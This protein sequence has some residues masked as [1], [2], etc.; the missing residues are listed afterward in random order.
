LADYDIED[1]ANLE[2]TLKKQTEKLNALRR[3]VRKLKFV[4]I[5]SAGY[6]SSIAYKSFDGGM[7]KLNFDPLEIDVIEV[8]DSNGNTKLKFAI[9]ISEELEK[10]DFTSIEEQPIVKKFLSIMGVNNLTEASEILRDPRELMEIA[11]FACIFDKITTASPEEKTIIMKDGLLRTKKIKSE[12]LDIL[13]DILKNKKNHVK[14]VGVAKTSKIVSLLSTALFLEKKIPQ[15]RIGYIKIPLELE[16][17]VYTWSGKGKITEKTERLVYSFGGLYIV[18]LSKL[19][20]ILVTLEI[21]EDYSTDEVNEIISYIAKDSKYSYPVLGYPQ[22]IMRAH[23]AAVRIGL[24]A[25]II[26]DKILEHVKELSDATVRKFLRDG[27]LFKDFVD[28]GVLGGGE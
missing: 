1:I 28:K 10:T 15:N 8:A 12:L 17:R 2:L 6:Y 16:L 11:E 3:E 18:K 21:P 7:F 23:E 5:E 22:T 14:L 19:S 9:P 20:N 25:S 27:W 13:K 4:P 26:K 24:P